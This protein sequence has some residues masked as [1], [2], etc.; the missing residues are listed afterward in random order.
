M[1]VWYASLFLGLRSGKIPGLSF[2]PV[3]V[4]SPSKISIAFDVVGGKRD[5][6][7]TQDAICGFE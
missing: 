1:Y 2:R 6:T 5:Y 4:L 7:V 3:N